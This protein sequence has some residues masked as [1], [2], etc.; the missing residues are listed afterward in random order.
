MTLSESTKVNV[1]VSALLA[2][3]GL[4][5][6]LAS[7]VYAAKE[8]MVANVTSAVKA[9]AEEMRQERDDALKHYLTREEFL[10]ELDARLDRFEARLIQRLRR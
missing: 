8:N 3:V 1:T 9:S 6:G 10:R 7:G 2:I 5:V 4:S